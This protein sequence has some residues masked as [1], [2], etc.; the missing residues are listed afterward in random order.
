MLH[1]LQRDNRR[2]LNEKELRIADFGLRIVE[3]ADCGFRIADFG[4][5]IVEI[6]DFGLWRLR[7]ADFGLRIAEIRGFRIK[8]QPLNIKSQSE[9]RNPKSAI[10]MIKQ[11]KYEL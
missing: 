3:I 5:R 10:N 8:M 11:C 4:L 2:G 1:W 9:I 6:S 7:I